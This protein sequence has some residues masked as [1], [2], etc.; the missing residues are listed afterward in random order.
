MTDTVPGIPPPAAPPP[1]PLPPSAPPNVSA[2]LYKAVIGQK[3]Q[4]TYL[5]HFA[6]FDAKGKTG[7]TWHWAAFLSALN[8]F[9]F[10]GMWGAA[11][12]YAAFLL[13]AILGLFGIGKLAYDFSDSTAQMLFAGFVLLTSV[14]GGLYAHAA[15]YRFC[16]KKIVE[17]VGLS[18]SIQDARKRLRDQAST[19][20][21]LYGLMVLNAALIGL[22]TWGFSLIQQQGSSAA[23]SASTSREPA[24]LPVGD[25]SPAPAP[26]TPASAPTST[27]TPETTATPTPVLTPTSA[28]TPTPDTPASAPQEKAPLPVSQATP[29]AEPP[30]P[31]E[32]EKPKVT[33]GA[34]PTAKPAS[35][36]ASSPAAA[37]SAALSS[38]DTR[39]FVQVGVFAVEDNALTL[40]EKLEAAGFRVHTLGMKTPKGVLIQVRVGPFDSK[41]DADASAAQLQAMNLPTYVF[42]LKP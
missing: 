5:R 17:T 38:V 4:A 42:K 2:D 12:L 23:P 36:P 16:K 7:P 19:N 20:R 14:L 6:Q 1:E 37:P 30:Q 29:L 21:R 24:T 10:R 35:R 31:R 26:T 39:Y 27:P 15:Y 34:K 22:A 13:A 3:N 32:S 33:P 9:I 11:L 41:A 25:N 8:W 18:S 28:A 40:Q